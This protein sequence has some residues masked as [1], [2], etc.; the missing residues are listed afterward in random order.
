MTIVPQRQCLFNFD[1]EMTFDNHTFT[2]LWAKIDNVYT[3]YGIERQRKDGSVVKLYKCRYSKSIKSEKVQVQLPKKRSSQYTVSNCG[4]K[5]K[6]EKFSDR[7]IISNI[8]GCEHTHTLEESDIY[9]RPTFIKQL[10]I[11]QAKYDYPCRLIKEAIQDEYEHEEAA[12]FID[13]KDVSN[14]K[15]KLNK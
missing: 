11:Q 12:K 10:I 8:G 7:V 14:A 13:S 6:V 1:K 2:N 15:T 4:F 3:T 5:L 9:R